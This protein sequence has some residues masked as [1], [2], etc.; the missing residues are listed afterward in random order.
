[1]RGHGVPTLRAAT[2]RQN[3]LQLYQLCD[4]TVEYNFALYQYCHLMNKLPT[5]FP[6]AQP[7]RATP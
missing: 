3:S 7:A 5:H 6:P 4:S 2:F 1:M